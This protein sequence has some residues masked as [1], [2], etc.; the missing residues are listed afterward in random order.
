MTP[1]MFQ[2]LAHFHTN[3]YH[4]HVKNW[5]NLSTNAKFFFEVLLSSSCVIYFSSNE[6]SHLTHKYSYS[7][8]HLQ[9][10]IQPTYS[11]LHNIKIIIKISSYDITVI[12]RMLLSNTVIAIL[13]GGVSSA[14][15]FGMFLTNAGSSRRKY[16][17]LTSIRILYYIF[18]SLNYFV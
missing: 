10:A 9:L 2:K 17:I 5:S 7:S 1:V 18:R 6:F 14:S 3:V 16:S 15:F 12:D 8:T 11:N 13:A 4:H